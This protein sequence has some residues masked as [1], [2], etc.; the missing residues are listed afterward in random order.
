[1]LVALYFFIT[2]VALPQ[3]GAYAQELFAP[4]MVLAITLAGITIIFGAVGMNVSNNLLATIVNGI[5]RAIGFCLRTIV[6]AIGWIIRSI[7]RMIPTVFNGCRNF[8][9]SCGMKSWLSVLLSVI[10]TIL[11]VAVV[12]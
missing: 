8:F 6:Q 7:F 10:V 11:C 2:K 1:M 9:R 5:F 3:I 4:I 12:I